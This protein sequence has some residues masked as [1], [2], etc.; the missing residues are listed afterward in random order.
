M[1]LVSS[2][3]CELKASSASNT[4]LLNLDGSPFPH[5][6]S[7][8]TNLV[9]VYELEQLPQHPEC[10]DRLIVLSGVTGTANTQQVQSIKDVFQAWLE[11][12]RVEAM[13]VFSLSM[14]NAAALL[15]CAFED[16]DDLV[17]TNV[18]KI[19]EYL[20]LKVDSVRVMGTPDLNRNCGCLT[21]EQIFLDLLGVLSCE[22]NK[23]NAFPTAGR[24]RDVQTHVLQ[25]LRR[26][27]ILKFAP[28]LKRLTRRLPK[29]F[30]AFFYK[31]LEK[32]S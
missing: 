31:R 23:E 9:V 30:V 6:G 12:Q 19:G 16:S 17:V 4:W 20:V 18:T 25:G 13:W 15:R 24:K 3:P 26:Q 28:R 10:G 32:T 14:P 21:P 8:G 11:N 2:A 22:T 5:L 7:I 1:K 29:W 27:L